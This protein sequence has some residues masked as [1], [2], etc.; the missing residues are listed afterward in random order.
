MLTDVFSEAKE[1]ALKKFNPLSRRERK[2]RKQSQPVFV[3]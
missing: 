1:I 3:L 2:A